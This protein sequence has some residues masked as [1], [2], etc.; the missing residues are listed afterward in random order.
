MGTRPGRALHRDPLPHIHEC[1]RARSC[2]RSS[3]PRAGGEWQPG[4]YVLGL[5]SHSRL[6]TGSLRAPVGV[7]ELGRAADPDHTQ[8][9][10]CDRMLPCPGSGRTLASRPV[11]LGHVRS[12]QSQKRSACTRYVAQCHRATR[13]SHQV[14]FLTQGLNSMMRHKMMYGN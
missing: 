2:L 4:G 12:E 5:G 10:G 11:S 8:S 9:R 14:V 1:A 3:E 7:T 13:G 6:R